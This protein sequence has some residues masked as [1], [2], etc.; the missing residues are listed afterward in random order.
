MT[1]ALEQAKDFVA[2]VRNL[3]ASSEDPRITLL[4]RTEPVARLMVVGPVL[5][6]LRPLVKG[7]EREL[8][9]RG[10]ARFE[11][12]SLAADG[13]SQLVDGHR[14]VLVRTQFDHET[15]RDQL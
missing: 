2:Q 7:L 13:P 12:R 5:E 4:T 15:S 11:V 3:P 8:R 1:N 6:Q 10:M 9:A 14:C